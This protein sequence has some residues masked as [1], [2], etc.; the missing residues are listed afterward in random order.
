MDNTYP[1]R[2]PS[3]KHCEAALRF[4]RRHLSTFAVEQ[5]CLWR[6]AW[7]VLTSLA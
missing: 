7:L 4:A 3:S 5:L 1:A 2:G 6:K